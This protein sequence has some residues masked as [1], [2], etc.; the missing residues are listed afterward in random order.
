MY[1]VLEFKGS[2]GGRTYL[3]FEEVRISLLRSLCICYADI[4]VI[5]VKIWAVGGQKDR[6]NIRRLHCYIQHGLWNRRCLAVLV[7]YLPGP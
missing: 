3:G 7:W 5:A 1:R 2:L 4:W 6:I